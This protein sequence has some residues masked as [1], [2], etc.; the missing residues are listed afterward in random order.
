MAAMR[1]ARA[2][3]FAFVPAAALAALA[4]GAGVPAPP[5][6]RLVVLG[7]AQDGGL[8]HAA[9]SCE[10]CLRARSRPLSRLIEEEKVDVALLDGTF[11]SLDELPG[12]AVEKIGHPPITDTMDRLGPRLRAGKLRVLF[13]HLNHPNPALAPE[14]AARRAIEAR[15]FAVAADGQEIEL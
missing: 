12:R 14:S 10:R 6:P 5:A 11:Y 15:G 3:V 4:W 9:C 13:T 1:S 2:A 7:T 8:P